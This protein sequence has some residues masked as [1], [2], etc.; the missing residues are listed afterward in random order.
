ML[1]IDND[2]AELLAIANIPY[3]FTEAFINILNVSADKRD[4]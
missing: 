4:N 3:P 2:I 1:A